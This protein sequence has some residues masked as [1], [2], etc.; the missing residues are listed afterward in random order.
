[1]VHLRPG[2]LVG[3]KLLPRL[4]R[5]HEFERVEVVRMEVGTVN[6]P[7]LF[8]V[9]SGGEVAQLGARTVLVL[10]GALLRLR[11]VEVLSP[12]GTDVLLV[13]WTR[14]ENFHLA[15]N[16]RRLDGERGPVVLDNNGTRSG[17]LGT[18][19]P[20]GSLQDVQYRSVGLL[21]LALLGDEF[22]HSHGRDLLSKPVAR[23]APWGLSGEIGIRL[24]PGHRTDRDG[25]SETLL[26][27]KSYSDGGL[28]NR[29]PILRTFL[30]PW[31]SC[32]QEPGAF[33]L[34]SVSG[35]SHKSDQV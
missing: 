34:P 19:Y 11:I 21:P 7:E 4:Q 20:H 12:G 13:P 26:A 18:I 23:K 35:L 8:T 32:S 33:R 14:I 17:V 10:F 16:A 5:R 25:G 27:L 9:E 29:S 15:M 31:L 22:A 1:V 3:T 30:G 24:L 2:Y 6:R 28:S